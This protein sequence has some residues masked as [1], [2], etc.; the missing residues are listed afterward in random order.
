MG[1]VPSFLPTYPLYGLSTYH[2]AQERVLESVEE[3]HQALTSTVD[4]KGYDGSYKT[5]MILKLTGRVD[6]G[7][8]NTR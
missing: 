4:A 2:S 1:Q 5:H 6:F 8:S 3:L 7:N